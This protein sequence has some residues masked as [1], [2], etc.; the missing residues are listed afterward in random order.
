MCRKRA[1]RARGSPWPNDLRRRADLATRQ[2]KRNSLEAAELAPA[3]GRYYRASNRDSRDATA[4]GTAG[5]RTG[6]G[7]SRTS[8]YDDLGFRG[9]ALTGLVSQAR[10][11][12]EAEASGRSRSE[13]SE[14]RR[15][16]QGGAGKA[17]RG[18]GAEPQPAPSSK[19]WLPRFPDLGP[20]CKP[21]FRRRKHFH[22]FLCPIAE[23]WK[24]SS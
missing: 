2:T 8:A 18:F 24:P 10:A 9:L 7:T 19:F 6:A 23:G 16:P 1:D 22:Q 17:H 5:P 20:R 21:S 3:R 15:S 11:E 14:R 13:R 4:A 12:P